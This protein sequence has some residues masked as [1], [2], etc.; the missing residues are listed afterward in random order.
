MRLIIV[1]HEVDFAGFLLCGGTELE[2]GRD[3]DG[4]VLGPEEG[5]H[6]LLGGIVP[7]SEGTAFGVGIRKEDDAVVSEG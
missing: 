3:A 7:H 1:I 2:E 4:I 5:L 6:D